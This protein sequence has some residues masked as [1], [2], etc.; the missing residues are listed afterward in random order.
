MSTA[1]RV[2]D[3]AGKFFPALGWLENRLRYPGLH[4]GTHVEIWRT[5]VLTHSDGVRIGAFSRLYL[6]EGGRLDLGSGV[7]LGRDVHV[8]TR[9]TVRIG[10]GS[11]I[12][13]G[14]RING[15]VAIG[16]HCV[17][18]PNLNVS[19]GQHVFRSAEPWRWIIDQER[20]HAAPDK[21]VTIGDDCWIGAHV[22]IMPGVT[23]GRGAVIG[24][25]AVV[26]KDIAPYTV[27]A[28]VPARIIGERLAFRP[29][30]TIEA[31]RPEDLPYFYSGFERVA[32]TAGG[33]PCDARF[34]V[35]LKAESAAS[36][37]EIT[38]ASSGGG[39]ISHEGDRQR[40]G[41]GETRLRFGLRDA[42][43]VFHEFVLEG[44]CR[45]VS[46][47]IAGLDKQPRDRQ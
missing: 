29:L 30:S 31:S 17:I 28:G 3:A 26:T 41:S 32:E 38:I 11:G 35:A 46:A 43:D 4:C 20:E 40:F 19:S 21:P 9:A 18:G 24:A 33:Y 34:T 13:D 39:S 44:E 45:L 15:D 1:A 36:G 42:S 6:Q 16:R 14:A 37:I 22:A 8:Q 10:A 12:N 5:G 7:H 27:A 23:V 47:R 2:F 25:N